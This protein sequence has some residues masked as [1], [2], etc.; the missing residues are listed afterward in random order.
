MTSLLLIWLTV[1]VALMLV[2][3]QDGKPSAGMP[4]AYFLG[5]SLLHAP[6]AA[7]YVVIP[8]WDASANQ[9]W[10]GFEQTVRGLVAFLIG[11]LV[12]RSVTFASRPSEPRVLPLEQL[13]ALDR[14]A[15]IY[16]FAGILYFVFGSII[17]IPSIGAI[18]A[19]IGSLVIVGACLRLWV[20]RKEGS[21]AK[22][23]LVM[24]WLPFLPVITLLKGGFL[25]MGISWLLTI[26]SFALSGSR[27]RLGYFLI[28]P[29]FVY[30]GL[31]VFVNY[32]ASRV[33]FR[34]AVWIQQVGIADRVQGVVDMFW[35]FE[36]YDSENPKHRHV[37]DER[38]NQNLLVGSAVERLE[39]GIK[40]YAYG[41]TLV[42]IAIGLI[43][44]AVWP[45]KPAVGGGG[46]IVQDFA[47][48]KVAGGTSVGAGQVLEF[49]VNFGTWGVIVGF[50][51]FGGLIGW[52]DFR[53]VECLSKGDQ[54]GFL[55]WFL[56]CLAL[57]QPGGN[58]LEIV[59]TAAASAVT[60]LALS[61]FLPRLLRESL[62][63][64]AFKA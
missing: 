22:L 40:D 20:A 11:V 36:W 54:R 14:L 61:D 31:S 3:R 35:N 30:V 52:M 37:I 50:L 63:A 34:Q 45:D 56:V 2:G 6:G 62:I 4:L 19:Q 43:P 5:L 13:A 33:E 1:G 58:L 24:L 57:I 17:S 48:L 42:D 59:V 47:G 18:I 49:Y 25:G 12:T 16:V 32:M 28:A 7:V 64:N 10:L 51:I 39:V 23:W 29:L 8:T 21:G 26:V 9:T 38:L 15:L 27:Q 41:A 46:S 55:L 60:A 44:R 53:I